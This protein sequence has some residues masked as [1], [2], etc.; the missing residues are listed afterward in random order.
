MKIV[1]VATRSDKFSAD[2]FAP[3]LP[4]E[5]KKALQLFASDVVR[6]IYSRKDGKGAIL[7][8]EAGDEDEA[9]AHLAELPL[10]A[11]GMLEFDV[12]P[13]GPYRGIAAIAES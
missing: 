12:Y 10:A 8:M 11:A 3:L 9:R 6:E 2:E 5:A 1:V 13:V 4:A 7:V